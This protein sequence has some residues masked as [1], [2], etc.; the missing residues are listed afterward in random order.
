MRDGAARAARSRA[1]TACGASA[2]DLRRPRLR[3][4]HDE[5][6]ALAGD[7]AAGRLAREARTAGLRERGRSATGSARAGTPREGV[8]ERGSERSA[9]SSHR[10]REPTGGGREIRQASGS[11][12]HR[13]APAPHAFG[14][15]SFARETSRT[16]QASSAHT[17]GGAETRGRA[18]AAAPMRAS[19][20]RRGRTSAVGSTC[21]GSSSFTGGRSSARRSSSSAPTRSP[22]SSCPLTTLVGLLVLRGG[23]ATSRSARG[24]ARVRV[25]DA[26]DR[27]RDAPRRRRPD[28]AARPHRRRGRTRSPRSTSSTSRSRRCSCR[29][30]GRGRSWP[31]ACSPSAGLFVHEALVG[32]SHHVR[33]LL[34]QRQMIEAHLRGMWVA[35]ALAAIFVVFFVQRVSSALAERERELQQARAHGGAPREARRRSRRSPP[36]PRTSS[37]RRSRPSRSSR[38]SWSARS[39]RTCRDEVRDDLQLVREQVARC[40][41][42]LDR[43]SAHAGENVGESLARLTAC[44]RGSTRR[45]TGSRGRDRVVVEPVARRAP[46]IVG[47][48]RALGDALRGLLK[49]ALQASG[50][51]A[52]GDAPGRRRSAAAVRAAVRDRGAGMPPEVLA[53]VGRAVLHHEGTRETGW[54]SVSS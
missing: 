5:Q 4:H 43:M 47:P 14:C 26:R 27:R 52:R 12:R 8:G 35:C 11:L 50:P 33:V 13:A 31:R 25:T 46:G 29:R 37:P 24:R 38:R 21:R 17:L 7:P 54:G 39:R 42:I 18:L 19:A 23:R 30:A 16:W 51:A 36:A 40:R 44:R 34:D 45:S 22:G 15:G 28:R 32:P 6:P 48:P 10:G 1:R 53:R 9:A 41:E 20:A 3:P 2:R 49:N